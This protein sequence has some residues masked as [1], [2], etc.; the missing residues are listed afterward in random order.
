MTELS[1]RSEVGRC[2]GLQGTISVRR[3]VFGV[4]GFNDGMAGRSLRRQIDL[5]MRSPFIRVALVTIRPA[6]S[7]LGSD[8]LF[9]RDLDAA[10]CSIVNAASIVL[11]A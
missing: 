9:Q 3:E 11:R 8:D 10:N 2:L 1:L 4:H 5:M 7:N 6:Q